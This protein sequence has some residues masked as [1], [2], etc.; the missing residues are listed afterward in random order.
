MGARRARTELKLTSGPRR[1][2]VS[3][4][5]EWIVTVVLYLVGIGLFRLLGGV[6]AAGDAVRRWGEAA[7]ALRRSGSSA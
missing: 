1:G 4:V 3:T 6:G 5:R 2:T 7:S